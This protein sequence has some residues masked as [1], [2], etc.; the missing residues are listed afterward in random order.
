MPG[1]KSSETSV[2][3]LLKEGQAESPDGFVL[4]SKSLTVSAGNQF[5]DYGSNST[6]NEKYKT[7]LN[8]TFVLKESYFIFNVT[9]VRFYF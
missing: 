4:K 5:N 1:G 9:E 3:E 8:F 7:K 2:K 6:H